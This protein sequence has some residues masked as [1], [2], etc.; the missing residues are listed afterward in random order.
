MNVVTTTINKNTTKPVVAIVAAL[1]PKYG[2]G[3]KGKLPWKLKKEMEYFKTVTTYTKDPSKVNAVIMGRKTW[4][5]IPKRFKPLP[6]RLN[7]IISRQ[8]NRTL[9]EENI[10]EKNIVKYNDLQQ[11]I[12]DL[13]NRVD[14][15]RIYII[16]GGEI[17]NQTYGICSHLLITEITNTNN[18]MN[19]EMDTFLDRD[20]ID[21]SFIKE[22]NE[23]KWFEFIHQH[24]DFNKATGYNDNDYSFDFTLYYHK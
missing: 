8:Y 3:Y 21:S 17:Y 1:L 10:K 16:G 2:I 24:K 9:A 23:T 7:V 22:T 18:S 15:E 11:S 12:I 4:E 20:K 14:I 6:N 19:L 13:Q 5:S